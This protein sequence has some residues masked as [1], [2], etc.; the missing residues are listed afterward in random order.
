MV[1]SVVAVD[2]STETV[3]LQGD[4]NLGILQTR[5]SNPDSDGSNRQSPQSLGG[6]TRPVEIDQEC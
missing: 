5:S 4:A 1:M 2:A 3:S 6:S